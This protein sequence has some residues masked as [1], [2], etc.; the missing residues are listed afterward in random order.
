MPRIPCSFE[1]YMVIMHPILREAEDMGRLEAENGSRLHISL[2]PITLK[3]FVL[4]EQLLMCEGCNRFSRRVETRHI[5]PNKRHSLSRKY[6][7]VLQNRSQERY[8]RSGF[9]EVA[10]RYG[11]REPELPSILQGYASPLRRIRDTSALRTLAHLDFMQVRLKMKAHYS[12]SSASRGFPST[13]G[14]FFK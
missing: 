4:S 8:A 14:I 6:L 11:T 7:A 2:E 9:G 12:I 10:C 3:D 1:A 5:M 13:V